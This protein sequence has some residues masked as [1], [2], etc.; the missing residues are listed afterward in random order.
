LA[1][2]LKAMTSGALAAILFMRAGVHEDRL[3]AMT[4]CA[5]LRVASGLS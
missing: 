3:A 1:Q 5:S 2:P 4:V